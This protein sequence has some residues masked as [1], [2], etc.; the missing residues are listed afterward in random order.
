M[1]ARLTE[2]LSPL[3]A[4]LSH[5]RKSCAGATGASFTCGGGAGFVAFCMARRTV[6]PLG[7]GVVTACVDTEGV[8]AGRTG[9]GTVEAVLPFAPTVDHTP[10]LA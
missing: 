5:L 3:S 10:P 9:I 1:Y 4:S 8:T 6:A 7:R 2:W